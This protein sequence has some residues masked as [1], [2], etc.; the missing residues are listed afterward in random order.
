MLLIFKPYV[1]ITLFSINICFR[2]ILKK[3]YHLKCVIDEIFNLLYKKNHFIMFYFEL[4]K[5]YDNAKKKIYV[6]QIST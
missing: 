5:C 2:K 4:I 6:A 1:M 3:C